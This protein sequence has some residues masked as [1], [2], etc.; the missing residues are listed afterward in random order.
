MIDAIEIPESSS[1]REAEGRY[2]DSWFDASA[3]SFAIMN[4]LARRRN[5]SKS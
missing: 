4:L 3:S 1:R 5:F 2:P